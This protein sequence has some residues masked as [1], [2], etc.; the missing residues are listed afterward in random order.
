MI[1]KPWLNLFTGRLRFVVTARS[2]KRLASNSRRG[3]TCEIQPA[4]V[5][6][7]RTLLT[8]TNP[9]GLGALDGTT[10]FRLD[11]VG[12]NAYSG[13][14]VSSAGDVNGDG[15]DDVIIGT[16]KGRVGEEPYAGFSYVVFGKASGFAATTDLSTLNGTNGFRVDGLDANDK[17]GLSVSGAG[18]I[19]G[20]GFDDLL[21]GVYAADPGGRLSAGESYVVFGKASFAPSFDF[22]TLTGAT[23][24]RLTGNLQGTNSGFSVSGGGDV[25]GD[26][27]D[28]LIIGAPY[29]GGNGAGEAFVFFGKGSGFAA[30]VA[31]SALDGTSGFQ[32]VGLSTDYGFGRSVSDAGDVNGDGFDDL[33]IGARRARVGMINSAGKT[34]VVFGKSSGFAAS[35][36]MSTL[37]GTNGFGLNGF[38]FSYESGFS[39]SSAGDFNGD[40]FADVIVGSPGATFGGDSYLI[41]GKA[42]GFSSSTSLSSLDGNN[43]FKIKMTNG[44]ARV[45]GGSVSEAGDVNG[46]GFDDLIIGDRGGV[47]PNSAYNS[48]ASY[49]LF[50][51]SGTFDA[52]ID[53]TSLDGDNG[54]RING[55]ISTYSARSVSGAGDV[56]GDGFADMIVS[57]HRANSTGS[58]YVVL[59]GNFTG[60]SETQVGT[61]AANAVTATQGNA[62]VDVL[63][64]SQ[65]NDT[66]ISDG[67]AD[68]LSGGEGTDT[69]TIVSTTFQRAAGGNGPDTLKFSGGNISLDLTGVA[70]TKVV[71]IETIDIT[72]SGENTLTVNQ[73]EVLNI[74]STSN[75]LI[76]RRGADDTV[77]KG[78]GWAQGADETISGSKFEVFTQGAA[79]LKIQSPQVSTSPITAVV[80]AGKLVITDISSGAVDVAVTLD[81][82]KSEYVVA[83]RTNGVTTDEFRFASASVTAGLS[84]TLGNGDDKLDLSTISLNSTVAG[85]TGNDSLVGGSGVDSISGED[86]NDTLTGGAGADILTAGV[87]TAD[88]LSDSTATDLVLTATE[89]R[90][91]PVGSA[92][93][94]TISGFEKALFFG[95]GSANS[96]SAKDANIP[97]SIFAGGGNDSLVGSSLA[98][99][100]DG[101]A[102]ND[103][104]TSNAGNDTLNGAAGTDL[105]KEVAYTD[106]VA[107]QTRTIT[108]ASNSL[109]VKQGVTTLSADTLLGFEIAD[110]TGGVMRDIL[111]ASGFTSSGVTSLS[112]GGGNDAITGTEGA[113][114]IFTL[115][116]ADLINGGGGGDSIFAGN[117]N[118]T[119]AGG[120]GADNLNGQNGDDSISG[121]A[122]NDVLIGGA[123]V[124]SMAGGLGNDFLSGQTEAGLMSGGEGNDTLQGNTA[125]DTL[126]GDAGDDRLYGLQG[127]DVVAGGDGADSL[128]GAAGTDSLSG[129]AGAD[130]LQGDIGN[131]TIDGGADSD[132]IN[133]VLDTNLTIVGITISTTSFGTDTVTA[134]ERIQ[135]SGGPS[136]NRFDARQATVPVFLA[137][138]AGDDTLLGGSKADG[139][140]GGNGN[141]VL[142]GG[143]GVDI[144]DGG[145]GTDVVYEVQDT[146]FTITGTQL[147]S[148]A[149]GTETP[150]NV[151]GFVLIGGASNNKLDA[152]AS[153]LPVT[154]LG[155]AGNDTLL[156]GAQADVLVG[157]HRSNVAIGTDS[158]T[159]NA[160]SDIFDNDP[161]DQRDAGK[162]DQVVA[163]VFTVLPTWVDAI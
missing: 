70:N 110:L 11:G 117:G 150:L 14:S 84:A 133:E 56:N 141:D 72:G 137:G 63:V 49:V 35:T 139:I 151:E 104:L 130:T 64:G 60:G 78:T 116:G 59:G 135:V 100:L 37:N 83:S 10:G 16:P 69:L 124:D 122:D 154:L 17:A 152:T 159:G 147:S 149:T 153:T 120:A 45:F 38:S 26:G 111:N 109:V 8:A 134:V 136:A 1:L 48:G 107:G 90:I 25:N 41:F 132:R 36:N 68:V 91:G 30:S 53:M 140:T 33:I 93:V 85:G 73:L 19:N 101:Q 3:S 29:G 79:T 6:E 40:G 28:D 32:M 162:A 67:G 88:V 138:D 61:N 96:M 75:T 114:L 131:D 95:G 7:P 97:V 43:G 144:L 24:F 15:F 142:S 102:G 94:D 13:Y 146:N 46:D 126:N 157:G 51:N 4:Q 108:L 86:G 158:L 113:D 81:T 54:F 118:D 65:G 18:D 23:G 55:V 74:S 163:N 2:K 119:I 34:Y 12:T 62:A 9:V 71:D 47:G 121:D 125:N 44:D 115:T 99:N 98:D 105:F 103:T 160:G 148:A 27:F 50:G 127:N 161:N 77:N 92:P 76:V 145:A 31:L 20:D 39:V 5:L 66:L 89:L 58:S 82:G 42:S 106:S 156:G 21:I 128:I 22:N 123:G 52:T 129:G 57:A 112:G 143:G 87:G 155:A 80:T